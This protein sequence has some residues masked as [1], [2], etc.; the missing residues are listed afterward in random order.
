MQAA[1]R[2]PLNI[3]LGGWIGDISW[4]EKNRSV[5]EH[6]LNCWKTTVTDCRSPAPRPPVG[7]ASINPLTDDPATSAP[8]GSAAAAPPGASGVPPVPATDPGKTMGIVA[9]IMSLF[10]SFF[11]I[12][13]VALILGIV[14][15]VKSKKAGYSNRWAIAAI[16]ISLVLMVLTVIVA[17][18]LGMAFGGGRW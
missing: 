13:I 7:S 6:T 15:L 9:F 1:S 10:V 4:A 11:L 16:I 17:I 18:I 5:R 14:A 8:Q 12:Q 3:A 2:A